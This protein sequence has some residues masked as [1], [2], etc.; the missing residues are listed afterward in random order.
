MRKGKK[1][2]DNSYFY[3]ASLTTYPLADP[4]I[5]PKY[6]GSFPNKLLMIIGKLPATNHP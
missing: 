3:N 6:G 4:I 5:L 1:K 2:T